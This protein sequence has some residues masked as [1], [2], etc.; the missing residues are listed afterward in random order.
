M[1]LRGVASPAHTTYK[2]QQQG[3]YQGAAFGKRWTI[4]GNSLQFPVKLRPRMSAAGEEGLIGGTEEDGRGEEIWGLK[5]WRPETFI[6]CTYQS[7][8][9]KRLEVP[10]FRAAQRNTVFPAA[11]V[12]SQIT[13]KCMQHRRGH[14]VRVKRSLMNNKWRMNDRTHAYW[15]PRCW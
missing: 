5:C 8:T 3:L 4:D 12:F 14:C 15:T 11:R 2:A 13:R 6:D 1:V 10:C 9:K 7:E